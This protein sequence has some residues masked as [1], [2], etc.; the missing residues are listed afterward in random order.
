MDFSKE[1]S[2]VE[3]KAEVVFH[4]MICTTT[5]IA[6]LIIISL[7]VVFGASL[8]CCITEYQNLVLCD[9]ASLS[10]TC[11]LMDSG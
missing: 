3:N 7:A 2:S 10:P 4:E 11:G 6:F 9:E 1:K 8:L 5:T